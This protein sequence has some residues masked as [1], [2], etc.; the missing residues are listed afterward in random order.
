MSD[1]LLAAAA[2]VLARAWQGEED[3]RVGALF[4]KD[5]VHEAIN[6]LVDALGPHDESREDAEADANAE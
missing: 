6:V 2:I 3:L 1:R 5:T 4:E